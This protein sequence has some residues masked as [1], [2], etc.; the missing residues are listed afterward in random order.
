MAHTTNPLITDPE[1]CNIV[2]SCKED[3]ERLPEDTQFNLLLDLLSIKDQFEQFGNQTTFI[4][5]RIMNPDGSGE[6]ISM[7]RTICVLGTC[8]LSFIQNPV[9][10]VSALL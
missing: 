7:R 6:I 8:D 2:I 4:R 3:Y 5:H 1:K 9:Y 10:G